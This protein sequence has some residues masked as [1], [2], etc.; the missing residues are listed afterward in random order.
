MRTLM[1]DVD[2]EP[3][4]PGTRVILRRRVDVGEGAPAM[5]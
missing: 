4:S 5:A 3:L 2:I 1:D